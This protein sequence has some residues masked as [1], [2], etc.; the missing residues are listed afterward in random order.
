MT[1]WLA[2]LAITFAAT[3]LLVGC[4]GTDPFSSG[5][6]QPDAPAEPVPTVAA[7]VE[8]TNHPLV[9]RLTVS[10]MPAGSTLE[11]EFGPTRHYGQRTAKVSSPAAEPAT[12]L[13][14]GMRADAL[15]SLRAR[16]TGADGSVHYSSGIAFRTGSLPTN[17]AEVRLEARTNPAMT[18]S[19]G[20]ELISAA[21]GPYQPY[22]TDL[23]G[24][25]IWY[26]PFDDHQAGLTVSGLRQLA[27]G[28]FLT[29]VGEGFNV[30]VTGTPDPTRSLVR[31]FDLL[32]AT[33]RQISI[34]DLNARLA[35]A[36][37]PLKLGV[38]HHHVEV[39][40]NG[41]WLL[42][43]NT[44]QIVDGLPVL[45]DVVVDVD[46]D[47]N[48]VWVWNSFDH[49]DVNRR[50]MELQDWT[51]GNAITY[52]PTDGNFLISLRHQH[53]VVKVDY[54][55]GQGAGAVIWRLGAGGDFALANGNDPSDWTYAQHYPVF[56]SAA[57]AGT[58]TLSLMDNGNERPDSQGRK[59]GSVG[60][61]SC[62]TTIPLFRIDEQARTA[63]ILSRITVPSDLFSPFGGNADI[64]ANGN[65]EYNLCGIPTGALIEERTADASHALVWSLRSLGG[66]FFYRAFRMTSLYPGVT[67]VVT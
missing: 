23:Q 3:M 24:R 45:G 50:P 55:D 49:L 58:F 32:G 8:Q 14:A 18:P 21:S 48:P 5:E 67:W 12:I 40:P 52:S 22:A 57:S 33:V 37:R 47:L 19:P 63:T 35:A 46:A 16:V 64:L 61:D 1:R 56:H 39:L 27:N 51:H 10:S 17:L 30:P 34:A 36:G 66:D 60:A 25:I 65:Y 43:A 38:F 54:R 44:V 26:Y 7:V 20:I 29:T 53:W 4:D 42:L 62:F 59:C 28:H 2:R 13:V 6:S 31:E 15:Y 11:A 9:A 41:H